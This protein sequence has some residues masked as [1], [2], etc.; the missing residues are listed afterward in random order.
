MKKRISVLFTWVLCMLPLL[1][2]SQQGNGVISVD[3]IKDCTHSCPNTLICTVHAPHV[4]SFY[5][6]PV[7]PFTVTQTADGWVYTIEEACQAS[8]FSFQLYIYIDSMGYTIDVP[9]SGPVS[10]TGDIQMSP[11]TCQ[12]GSTVLSTNTQ[13]GTPPYTYYFLQN[14]QNID[15]SQLVNGP[16]QVTIV[17]ST[18]CITLKAGVIS[19]QYTD[20]LTLYACGGGTATYNGQAYAA[21]V[22]TVPGGQAPDGCDSLIVLT[23]REFPAVAGIVFENQTCTTATAAVSNVPADLTYNWWSAN[24]SAIVGDPASPEIGI[25]VDGNYSVAITSPSL[26]CSDTLSASWSNPDALSV[27][28]LYGNCPD[29]LIAI[30]HGG[31]PPYNFTWQSGLTVDH[32]FNVMDSITHYALP[33][34]Y[35]TNMTVFVSPVQTLCSGQASVT[36]PFQFGDFAAPYCHDSLIFT[37][38]SPNP[39]VSFQWSFNGQNHPGN[40]LSMDESGTVDIMATDAH[41][42][43]ISSQV[44][45]SYQPTPNFYHCGDQ[46]IALV[47]SMFQPAQIQWFGLDPG[48]CADCFVTAWPQASS[49]QYY[50]EWTDPVFQVLNGCTGP[51]LIL[52]DV[53]VGCPNMITG[54]VFYDQD[55]LCAYDSTEAPRPQAVITASG[56][57]GTFYAYS[58]AN[59]IYQMPLDP[60]NYSVTMANPSLI[61]SIC[62]PPAFV[63][64]D[65]NEVE[66]LNIG[67]T[68]LVYCPVLDVQ[69]STPIL[70]KCLNSLYDVHYCNQ[71]TAAADNAYLILTL[72]PLVSVTGASL[73][74]I[75]LGNGQY[76]FELGSI[77]PWDCGDFQVFVTTSCDAVLHQTLCAEAHIYPDDICTPGGSS[78]TGAHLD[79]NALCQ[80]DS[81]VFNITNIGAAAMT[82]AEGSYKIIE[83]MIILMQ[84]HFNPLDVA[85]TYQVKVPAN[86]STWRL[87]TP[88]EDGFPIPSFPSATIEGCVNSSGPFSTGFANQYLLGD[89][90]AYTDEFCTEVRASWDP[91]EKQA[92]P[93]GYS[94]SHDI[95]PQTPIE[96]MIQFQNTGTDTAFRVVVLDTLSASLDPS[97]LQMGSGSHPHRVELTGQ[98]VLKVTFDPIALP[99]STTNELA[100][101]GYFTFSI[102]PRANAPLGMLI[103][104]TAAIY[105]DQ[106]EPVFTNTTWHTLGIDFILSDV[107]NANPR[108]PFTVYPNPTAGG[109][110]VKTQTPGV[111][112]VRLNDMLGHTM[113]NTS[114]EGGQS[115]IDVS[116]LPKG[117]FTLVVS[118][119]DGIVYSAVLVRD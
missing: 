105:F 39:P 1:V 41:G 115:F 71:G 117:M 37:A 34:I 114:F 101:H 20:N 79:V 8:T 47:P 82:S 2:M 95:L 84:G 83:D 94:E 112:Q 89:Q 104:N 40:I 80:G 57:N 5:V 6:E 72:D 32:Q 108:I 86:G 30:V 23:V 46:L 77:S 33:D 55:G 87:E 9:V 110:Y 24:G 29:T 103:E 75:N 70:R 38:Q 116:A 91:N 97:T 42:C 113:L 7:K 76:R 25:V 11:V 64:L 62:A 98:G 4:T 18:G 53:Q 26:G 73:N 102:R 50:L 93:E 107:R 27:E 81:V 119:A 106:N 90:E 12:A 67:V 74:Y 96:Y 58:Q 56:A 92:F 21:G 17:D 13:Y 78:W 52:A 48:A 44:N 3:V 10:Y 31:N 51:E 28:I 54:T 22:H 100:S 63:S 118:N 16:Y 65:T 69:I 36:L 43:I 68:P 99:D 14:N 35:L 66:A 45:Y 111:Y 49:V 60:G 109:L 19:Y 88:Q 59:G 15:A 61:E 85:E